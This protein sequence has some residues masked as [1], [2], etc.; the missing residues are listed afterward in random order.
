VGIINVNGRIVIQSTRLAVERLGERAFELA[1]QEWAEQ[2][3]RNREEITYFLHQV[4]D[5][6]DRLL[7]PDKDA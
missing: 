5:A 1:G 2:A 6:A 3:S 7:P 4:C